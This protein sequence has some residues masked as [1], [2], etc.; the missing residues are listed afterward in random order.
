M[1]NGE[2][3][4]E[5]GADERWQ[6]LE[7]LAAYSRLVSERRYEEWSQLF[8]PDGEFSTPWTG[9]TAGRENLRA[10]VQDRQKDWDTFKQVTVNVTIDLNG[11][12]AHALSDYFLLR[13]EDG[14]IVVPSMGRYSDLLRK[15]DGRWR[16]AR[17]EVVA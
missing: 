3:D 10:F 13:H 8:L 7:T 16:F 4:C 17:R 9:V 15:V 6:V 1:R 14:R 5:T 11:D 12:E 2:T